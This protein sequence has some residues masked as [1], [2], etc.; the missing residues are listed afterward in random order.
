M[1]IS[2]ILNGNPVT[3]VDIVSDQVSGFVDIVYVNNENRLKVYRS[4]DTSTLATSSSIISTGIG[5]ADTLDG[6]H[7][8]DF[9]TADGTTSLTGDWDVGDGLKIQID[10]IQAR[11]ADGLKLTNDGGDGIT[12]ADDGNVNVDGNI[13]IPSGSKYKIDGLDLSASDVDLLTLGDPTYSTIQDWFVTF[14]SSG[15]ISGGVII[16]NGD[17]TIK[18]TAG[19]GYIKPT[20]DDIGQTMFFDWDENS[21]LEITNNTTKYVYVSY[22]GGSPIITVSATIPEDRNTNVL[23]GMVY[24]EDTTIHIVT[25]GLYVGGFPNHVFFKDIE[26]NGKLQRV[27]G[28][29]ISETGVRNFEISSGIVYAGYTRTAVPK[30]DSSDTDKFTYHYGDDSHGWTSV[31]DQTQIDNIQYYDSTAGSLDDLSNSNRYGVHWVYE[32]LSGDVHVVY[33]SGDYTSSEAQLAQP[34]SSVPTLVKDMCLLIGKIV[35][36][37]GSSS[38]EPIESAFIQKFTPSLVFAHNDLSALQGG[39]TDEY[40]HLT[41]AEA[42]AVS[43]LGKITNVIKSSTTTLTADEC[44][45]TLINNYGQVDETT[46]TLPTADEGLNFMAIIGTDGAGSFHLKAGSSDKIYLDGTAL[47]DGDKVS[48]TTPVVGNAINFTS[49][50]TGASSYDWIAQTIDGTWIDGGV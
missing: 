30:F 24:R 45:G 22:N 4:R 21:S 12:I 16:D 38:F 9:V 11:D 39:T 41:A 17:G 19:T 7:A 29:S 13:N 36:Q 23:L 40:Y 31:A 37:K 50:Q 5:D 25:A 6:K 47:D 49:F 8:S 35:I 32:E 27:S 42:T 28:L 2:A 20:D 14:Q 44:K 34:P 26:V 43:N 18:V 3:I 15:K 48:L 10:E 46:L 1:K 33:G